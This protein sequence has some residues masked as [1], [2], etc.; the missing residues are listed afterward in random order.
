M[1]EQ[2]L[3]HADSIFFNVEKDLK[4]KDNSV[5]SEQKFKL[6]IHIFYIY[7]RCYFK[8]FVDI[9]ILYG[10]WAFPIKWNY[11]MDIKYR[12]SFIGKENIAVNQIGYGNRIFMTIKYLKI[13]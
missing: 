9:S 11:Y 10:Q 8:K 5:H 7:L 6:I 2:C 1:S 13:P 12:R 3:I 4:E